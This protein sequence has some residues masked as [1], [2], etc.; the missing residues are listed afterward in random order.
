M[1]RK[2]KLGPAGDGYGSVHTV[3]IPLWPYLVA[4][5]CCV[6][7]LPGSWLVHHT[8]A[9]DASSA[10]WTG[11]ALA[12][13]A[14]G[15]AI[16][17][18]AASIPRGRVM[19][20][21]A[22]GNTV[23]AS[24]WLIPAI[25]EGPWSKAMLGT[26]LLG[27]LLISVACAV[28]RIMRQARGDADGAGRVLDGEFGEVADAV[29]QLKGARFG[30]PKID[31]AKVSAEIEMPPGRTFSEVAGAKN[32]VASL[33]DVKATSIRTIDGTDSERRGRVEIV[34]VDQLRD[35]IPDP[36]PSAPGRSIAE[37]IVL[38]RAENGSDAAIILPGDPK[39]HRN[40]VGVMGVVGMSGSGKTELLLRL[41][42]EVATRNDVDLHIADARKAG[43]LPAWLKRA[44]KTVAAGA[45]DADELLETLGER[46]AAR[47][48]ELG[49]RG[50]K[51]WEQ[52]CGL[53]FEVYIVFEAAAVVAGNKTVVDLAESVRSVGI[54]LILEVQRATYDRLPTSAR[55]NITT[56]VVLGV[57]RDEDAEAA[58]SEDTIR[59]GAMPWKWKNGKPGYF[60]LEWAGRDQE[61]WSAPCR[62]FIED[63]EQ[64]A[65]DVAAA[66]GWGGAPAAD[67][68]PAPA[69][70]AE[71]PEPGDEGDEVP[72][73]VDPD[74]P[75]DDVDP[76]EP[77]RVPPDMPRLPLGDGRKVPSAVAMDLLRSK[78]F[79]LGQAGAEYLK[80]SELG[81]VLAQTGLSGSWL[82]GALRELTTGDEPVLAK[83]Q[84]GVY[85]IL[86]PAPV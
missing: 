21:M 59:A 75:P 79:D 24:L 74:D 17:V 5:L 28:Y 34:P 48:A 61:L 78:I 3:R 23:L 51:Q 71:E 46:V 80:P 1:G 64:R 56:W 20:F 30:S 50:F 10:G 73:G 7:A 9:R 15:M 85:R 72:P 22:T 68:R 58:L 32:E 86:T 19:N 18:F 47:A 52:G 16:F 41:G 38:G 82:Y 12:L 54:C 25:L 44:A 53:P 83:P 8:F 76:A 60:Y 77:I 35:P 6:A 57:E 4:P 26:W 70:A 55:S 37:P 11:V 43:Q 2:P 40:A 69:D 45:D 49:K 67:S 31:G 14:V 13:A 36:G 62:S 42:K 66:L 84:R 81:D 39:A 33:L 29:K 63:D 65:A 27:T